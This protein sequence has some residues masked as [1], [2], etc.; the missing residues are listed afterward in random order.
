MRRAREGGGMEEGE[1]SYG[2]LLGML[3]P[4]SS[5]AAALSSVAVT[6]HARLSSGTNTRVWSKER[7]DGNR[8]DCHVVPIYIG[9]ISVRM[10][11]VLCFVCNV[12]MMTS[13]L[14]GPIRSWHPPIE[15]CKQYVFLAKDPDIQ[16]SCKARTIPLQQLGSF[17][18]FR[19]CRCARGVH[20]KRTSASMPPPQYSIIQSDLKLRAPRSSCARQ[21]EP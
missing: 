9:L 17:T 18:T 3:I 8:L 6:T 16:R 5:A 1:L 19:P 11:D 2:V 21:F 13:R 7:K 15:A 4:S 20:T 12:L 10:C 14:C